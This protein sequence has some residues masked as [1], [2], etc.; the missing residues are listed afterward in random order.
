MVPTKID[1][2][3][4]GPRDGFQME[5]EFIPTKTKAE[6]IGKM[7]ATG[8]KK[9]EVTSFV[10]PRLV[11]QL[12]DGEELMELLRGM[13]YGEKQDEIQFSAL[14]L[15]ERGLERAI[16]AQVEEVLMV[17]SAS[18]THSKSNVNMTID[19]A[20]QQLQRICRE[21]E[22]AGVKVR[23]A[24]GVAFDCPFEGKVPFSVLERIT[25]E[26]VAMGIEEIT[27]GDTAGLAHPLQVR[28][29]MSQLREK[30]E[31][32]TWGLHFHDTRGLGLANIYAGME[33]GVSLLETS[34]GGLGGC[35]FVPQ[36]TGNVATEDLVNMLSMMGIGTGVDLDQ[37]LVLA[38]ETQALLGRALPSRLLSIT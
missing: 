26:M 4:V 10:N 22:K 1:I 32:I 34:V 31:K 18:E 11:S 24:L 6:I 37:L 12:K 23:G 5:E 19:Q 29:I 36:A 17:I 33:E 25:G 35:P 13:D 16:Q 3:E 28:E 20:L 38:Q 7:V 14:I 15:N 2:R 8:L 27:L 9:I 21:G 30:H